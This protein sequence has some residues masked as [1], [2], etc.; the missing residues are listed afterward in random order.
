MHPRLPGLGLSMPDQKWPWAITFITWVITFSSCFFFGNFLALHVCLS[1]KTVFPTLA[2]GEH[3][4]I[5]R[6]E[7]LHA[8][9]KDKWQ[10]KGSGI[11][12]ERCRN[13]PLGKRERGAC[14]PRGLRQ[15]CAALTS[16]RGR[17]G[18]PW[19]ACPPAIP[20]SDVQRV[21]TWRTDQTKPNTFR[22]AADFRWFLISCA[23]SLSK[24]KCVLSNS[25]QSLAAFF[26]KCDY[27]SWHHRSQEVTHKLQGYHLWRAPTKGCVCA[28]TGSQ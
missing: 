3:A 4:K 13:K 6:K 16:V 11:V 19:A 27:C 1:T 15:E 21:C 22:N 8:Y 10:R 26:L 7:K 14:R 20:D 23:L 9:D 25:T 18:S 24:H 12:R 17:E 2:K 28:K 5:K